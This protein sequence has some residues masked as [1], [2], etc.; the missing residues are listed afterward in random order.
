[1]IVLPDP[2]P[3]PLPLKPEPPPPS[4][5]AT[6]MVPAVIELVVFAF[7]STVLLLVTLEFSM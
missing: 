4:A 6:P 3:A 1:M 5:T 2:A 7:S